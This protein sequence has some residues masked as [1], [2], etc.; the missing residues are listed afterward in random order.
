MISPGQCSFRI[1]CGGQGLNIGKMA[2]ICRLHLR[3]AWQSNMVSVPPPS[4]CHTTQSLEVCLLH[5]SSCWPFTGAQGESLHT[6]L[7]AGPLR[8]MSE[9]SVSFLLTQAAPPI[10]RVRFCVT[11]SSWDWNPGLGIRVPRS[12]SRASAASL[13]P[14]VHLPQ[15]GVGPACFVSPPFLPISML[16]FLY[17]LI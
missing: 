5:S 16:L 9:I 17:I 3:G 15:V 6:S 10:F 12:F 11:S 2:P 1:G 7:C 4:G 14:T 8:R 13:P